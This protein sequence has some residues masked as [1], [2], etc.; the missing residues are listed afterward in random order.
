VVLGADSNRH[1]FDETATLLAA[2]FNSYTPVRIGRKGE[3]LGDPVPVKGGREKAVR[4][5]APYD[6]TVILSRPDDRRVE[7]KFIPDAN[8]RAPIRSGQPIGR[9]EV[10]SGGS[11]VAEM[12]LVAT[13]D[14]ARSGF[15]RRLFGG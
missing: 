13:G 11:M 8:L 9:V 7:K 1:R 6:L 4:G 3:A 12:P 10:L 2:G 14:V 15:F 5:A